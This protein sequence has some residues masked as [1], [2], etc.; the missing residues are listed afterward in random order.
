MMQHSPKLWK[1]RIICTLVL[2]VMVFPRLAYCDSFAESMK[3]RPELFHPVTGLRID[4][5]RAPTPDDI[6]PPAVIINTAKAAH[7]LE[8][9]AVAID[10]FGASQSHY[11]E[12]EGTW[13][14]SRQHQSLPGATWLPEVGRGTL[15]AQMQEYLAS[16]IIRLTSGKLNKPLVVYC[17]ADCWMSWNA[18]Q[19][20][21]ALGYTHVNWYRLGTDGWLE[22]GRE[23]L[24]VNPVPVNVE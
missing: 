6:P 9:G 17:I 10:V 19:R 15:S 20:I 13:L 3:R 8:N 14:V 24:P 7:L 5:Q 11:D 23:L 16:N 1:V 22:S 2:V 12:L 4:R 21:A 18:S